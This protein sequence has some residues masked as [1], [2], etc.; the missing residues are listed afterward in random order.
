MKKTEERHELDRALV[1]I[2]DWLDHDGMTRS[3]LGLLA[4]AN[5]HAVDRIFTGTAQIH[6]LRQVLEYL[7]IQEGK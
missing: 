7:D 1:R 2:A 4:C 3:R 6:T 5:Q